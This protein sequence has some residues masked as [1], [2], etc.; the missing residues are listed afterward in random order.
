MLQRS[1]DTL[2]NNQMA[3]Y[4]MTEEL[5]EMQNVLAYNQEQLSSD[6]HRVQEVLNDLKEDQAILAE[7]QQRIF[8]Q[9]N[10]IL[11]GKILSNTFF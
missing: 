9:T 7:N 11:G 4:E 2:Q 8:D 3:L 10:L 1:H 5:H 6:V